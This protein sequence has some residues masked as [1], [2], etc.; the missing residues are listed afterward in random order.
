MTDD[1]FAKG[2][3][4]ILKEY[5]INIPIKKPGDPAELIPNW[6]KSNA[7]WWSEGQITDLDFKNGI[8]FLVKNGIIL[9]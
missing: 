1:R 8:D 7:K 9:V 6:F 3:E 2:I 4:S 5:K